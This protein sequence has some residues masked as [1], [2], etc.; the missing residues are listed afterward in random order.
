MKRYKGHKSAITVMAL[1]IGLLA[2]CDEGVSPTPV[3]EQEEQWHQPPSVTEVSWKGETAA[4]SGV[5]DPNGRVVFMVQGG[6]SYAASADNAGRFSLSVMVPPEGLLL[7]P[8]LQIGQSTVAGPGQLF[9]APHDVGLAAVLFPGDPA[10]RLSGEGPLD[11]VDRDGKALVVTGRTAP[12]RP[13]QL[14]VNGR[15]VDTQPDAEGRWAVVLP[16]SGAPSRVLV[17]GRAYEVPGYSADTSNF[18]GRV[19]DGWLVRR[20]FGDGAVQS[21]WFPLDK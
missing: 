20:N 5:A 8:R 3:E 11:A 9:I 17:G 1:S 12:G 2:A 15:T 4:V 7:Q 13:P 10:L 18:S 6:Q 16:S 14:E 21:T 19:G